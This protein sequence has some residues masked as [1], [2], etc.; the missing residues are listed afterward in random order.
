ML[1]G[2]AVGMY[3]H[4]ELEGYRGVWHMLAMG[5]PDPQISE[6]ETRKNMRNVLSKNIQFTG[7]IVV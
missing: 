4:Q 5:P 6:T 3:E 1:C 2:E 7:M